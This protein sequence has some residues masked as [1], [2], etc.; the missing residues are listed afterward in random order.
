MVD[1][2]IDELLRKI[3]LKTFTMVKRVLIIS[4]SPIQLLIPDLQGI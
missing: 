3:E 1:N 2:I 4:S